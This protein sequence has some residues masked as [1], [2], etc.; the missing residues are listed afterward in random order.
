MHETGV[1]RSIVD[2]VEQYALMA[3]AKRVK[4]VNIELGEVHD[5]VPEILVGAFN[6]M[7]RDTIAEG[8]AMHIERVPFTVECQRC[9]KVYR[10]DYVDSRT[11]ACPVCAERDYRL[12]T[13]REFSIVS[14]EIEGYQPGETDATPVFAAAHARRTRG[15][16]PA[17]SLAVAGR[18]PARSA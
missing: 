10:L 12:K 13:G 2:T 6:W 16:V 3:H 8:A 15:R 4:T 5:I 14:I 11:W 17:S 1:C 9:G 18:R 7:C